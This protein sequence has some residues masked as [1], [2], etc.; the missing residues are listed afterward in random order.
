MIIREF[1]NLDEIKKYY[2]KETNTYIFKE[3]GEY[4]ELIVFKFNLDI[5]A[6]IDA[7]SVRAFNIHVNNIDVTDIRCYDMN[8]KNIVSNDIVAYDINAN[9]IDAWNIKAW[10]I[11]ADNINA[12][13]IEAD[14]INANDISYLAVCFAYNSIECKTIKGRMEGAKHFVLWER[15]KVK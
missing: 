6:N 4:I 11:K 7:R 9:D 13:N 3:N 14:S 2:D 12:E 10:N 5:D 1:N 8:V 15:L